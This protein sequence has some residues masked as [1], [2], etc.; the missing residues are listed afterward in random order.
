MTNPALLLGFLFLRNPPKLVKIIED[1]YIVSLLMLKG[2]YMRLLSAIVMVTTFS[3]NSFLFAST[4]LYLSQCTSA[5][6]CQDSALKS[7]A[8]TVSGGKEADVIVYDSV[9]NKTHH[10]QVVNASGSEFPGML[11]VGSKKVGELDAETTDSVADYV[12]IKTNPILT[13]LVTRYRQTGRALGYD[14]YYLGQFDLNFS[15][16]DIPTGLQNLRYRVQQRVANTHLELS[17]NF[18]Q[19]VHNLFGAQFGVSNF[20]FSVQT[21]NLPAIFM[22]TSD[23]DGASW[24]ITTESSVTG[25]NRIETNFKAIVIMEDD[26]NFVLEIPVSNNRVDLAALKGQTFNTVNPG[27]FRTWF[28]EMNLDIS[29]NSGC[30]NCVV[31]I[32]DI[33]DPDVGEVEP[34]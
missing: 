18:V 22:L 13:T 17:S 34:E 28:Q 25:G 15:S 6:T 7:K 2:I 23:S 26:G 30:S 19:Q 9:N 24:G 4:P 3:F 27:S 14:T 20:A 16:S 29:W 11:L 31:T 1:E 8:I 12:E 10:Y 5:T 21:D 33:N 32:T